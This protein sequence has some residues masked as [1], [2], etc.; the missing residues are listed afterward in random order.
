MVNSFEGKRKPKEV[1]W[2][3][4]PGQLYGPLAPN[5]FCLP[6]IHTHRLT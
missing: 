6:R 3:E 5:K 2:I 1:L 4:L